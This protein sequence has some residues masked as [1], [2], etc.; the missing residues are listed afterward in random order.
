MSDDTWLFDYVI[1]FL[2]SPIWQ[3]PVNTFIDENCAAF[4]DDDAEHKLIHTELHSK[5]N[6]LIE[7]LLSNNLKQIGVSDEQFIEAVQ[8]GLTSS[9]PLNRLLFDQIVASTD[10]LVFRTIMKSRNG[11]LDAE[12]LIQLSQPNS[13]Q[14]AS[15]NSHAQKP[16]NSQNASRTTSLQQMSPIVQQTVHDDC[17]LT[18]REQIERALLLSQRELYNNPN[19]QKQSNRT[20]QL[21]NDLETALQMSLLTEEQRL[22]RLNELERIEQDAIERALRESLETEQERVRRL[23]LEK[24]RAAQHAKSVLEA[25]RPLVKIDDPSTNSSN[26]SLNKLKFRTSNFQPTSSGYDSEFEYLQ[27]PFPK[28]DSTPVDQKDDEESDIVEVTEKLTLEASPYVPNERES[29]SSSMNLNQK[30]EQVPLSSAAAQ[31]M[32]LQ[33]LRMQTTQSTQIT[34]S[35]LKLPSPSTKAENPS[36]VIQV[37][38]VS[39]TNASTRKQEEQTICNQQ[40]ESDVQLVPSSATEQP[41][42]TKPSLS[43]LMTVKDHQ[44]QKN[45]DTSANIETSKPAT[46]TQSKLKMRPLSAAARPRQKLKE[47]KTAPQLTSDFKLHLRQPSASS[48]EEIVIEEESSSPST[49]SKPTKT[50]PKEQLIS[51]AELRRRQEFLREQRRQLLERKSKERQL[52]LKQYTESQSQNAEEIEYEEEKPQSK[53]EIEAKSLEALINRLKR[54]MQ[55][56]IGAS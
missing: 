28:P 50:K 14:T 27:S 38:T 56:R 1:E 33:Q 21:Q 17:T 18:E 23:M 7:S 8:K 49:Q 48:D 5:F 47:L 11:E 13:P 10:F 22:E 15:V 52:I 51:E 4:S 55:N 6:K 40:D 19:T 29:I 45:D 9:H 43:R 25:T 53:A 30:D 20:R 31:S 36:S 34:Q 35:G 54:D 41:K 16:L 46:S 39:T 3:T 2:R 32:N 24:E 12:A 26:A 44:L 42:V 37:P